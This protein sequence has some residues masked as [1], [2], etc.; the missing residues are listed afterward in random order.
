MKKKI[1]SSLK[2]NQNISIDIIEAELKKSDITHLL[3]MS[4]IDSKE[5]KVN[6]K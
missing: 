3:N 5:K 6:D 1:L 2:N 4:K